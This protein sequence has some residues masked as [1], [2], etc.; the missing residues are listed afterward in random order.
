MAP[1]I[2]MHC[3]FPECGRP[4]R[5]RDLCAA[6]GAQRD[7]G[8]ALVPVRPYSTRG[9][10]VSETCIAEQC[11]RKS[12]KRGLCD[13]H[14]SA[15]R[16][17]RAFAVLDQ[18]EDEWFYS[19]VAEKDGCWVWQSSL[20]RDGY[21]QFRRHGSGNKTAH[22][23]SYEFMRG[24]IP[25]G[26]QLDHLCRNRACVNPEHLEPVTSLVN[27]WRGI[28]PSAIN[29]RKTHCDHG[30]EFTP[31]NTMSRSEGG[32]RCRTCVSD[33]NARYARKVG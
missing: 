7:K 21:G 12:A 11:S 3:V 32:R 28:A 24:E 16:E 25:P 10:I 20:N 14:Y 17:G 18:R 23:W 22:R 1:N 19:R 30:H 31:E 4:R 9:E 13:S 29:A 5:R 15:S 6:H 33:Y 2:D 26:L 8:R 27:W